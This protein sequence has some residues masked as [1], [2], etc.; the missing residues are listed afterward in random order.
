MEVLDFLKTVDS[1][2]PVPVYLFS[3]FKGPKAREATFEPVLAQRA[4]DRLVAL[5]VDPNTRDLA[6]STYYADEADPGEIVSV[7]QT[8][9]F[10]SERQVVV[11]HGAERYESETA[12][13]AL[14]NYLENPVE[15]TILIMIATRIDKRSKLYKVCSKSAMIVECPEMRERDAI[16]WARHEFARLGKSIDG[17]ALQELVDRT[18]TRLSDVT[19]AI[20]LLVNFVGTNE[21]VTALDVATACA[22]VAEEEIWSLTDAI[23][24]SDTDK[25]VR[26]LR[27][28]L[29]LGKNEFEI[30]G[31]INWLLKTAYFAAAPSSNRLKPFLADKVRPLAAKLGKEKFRDA[32]SLCMDTEILLRSTGVDRTLALELLVVKLAAPRRTARV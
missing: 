11:I 10:L 21:T 13:G 24:S 5:Y 19:N 32:F 2:A 14:L 7:C 29:D 28:I 15:S 9:P 23:A 26:V 6:Y 27:D 30:L 31:S 12:A 18:G 8:L 4:V 16:A 22:D 17:P 20:N 1:D 3:P 25:A